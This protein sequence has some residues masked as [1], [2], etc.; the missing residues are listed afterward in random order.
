MKRAVIAAFDAIAAITAYPAA[1]LL[2]KIRRIGVHRLPRSRRTLERVGVFPIRDHYYEPQFNYANAQVSAGERVL[3]G[4]DWNVPEQLSLLSNLRYAD[5]LR[6]WTTEPVG[7]GQFS[8]GNALFGSGDAEFWY[9]LIRHVKP[10]RI[11][12]IGSGHSTL[13]AAE[14]IRRSTQENPEYSCKHVCVEPFEAPWLETTGVVVVRKQV[15]RL[16]LQFFDELQRDDILFIDSSHVIRPHGDVTFEYLTLLPALN[17][18]V[19]V[20]VHDI[21]S[22]RN[23]PERWVVDEVRLWNEQYLLEAFL[24]HNASWKI[25]AALNYLKHHHYDRLQAVGPFLT[26]DREPGSFYMQKI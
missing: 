6:D 14:A 24:T 4:I 16:P 8:I 22:P 26:P 17:S 13:V 11:F 10:R 9:Q 1:L 20:H 25:M 19:I 12:E 21:F 3:P 5:E 15:E 7:A 18:G 2:A 23:Y